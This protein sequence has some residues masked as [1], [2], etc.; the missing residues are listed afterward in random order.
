MTERRIWMRGLALAA[1]TGALV[2]L[3][4]CSGPVRET[5]SPA[6]SHAAPEPSAAPEPAPAV[7]RALGREFDGTE[8]QLDLSDVSPEDMDEILSL[9][10]RLPRLSHIKT[11]APDGEDR[12]QLEE[13]SRLRE[14]LDREIP[15]SCRFELFGH[16]VSSEDE[17]ISYVR[18]YIGDEQLPSLRKALPLLSGCRR[19]VLDDCMLTYEKLAELREEFPERGLVWRV[20]YGVESSL[21]DDTTI[22]SGSLTDE[23]CDVLK[24]CTEVLYLDVGENHQQT[25]FRFLDSMTKL[26]VVIVAHTKFNY[27]DFVTHCPDL[28]YLEL[29]HTPV[30]DLTPLAGCENLRHLSVESILTLTDITPLYQLKGLERLRICIVPKVPA[31]QIRALS[32]ELPDTLLITSVNPYWRR[33]RNGNRVERYI[34]LQEQIGYSYYF[35]ATDRVDWDYIHSMGYDH[36]SVFTCS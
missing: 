15:I 26:Q 4:G 2:L 35:R 12:W 31:E 13:L 34:L 5:S 32:E 8:T 28:E 17:E 36:R 33:D 23:N 9:I 1:L 29:D 22:W 14:G 27:C 11:E 20:R 3:A 18:E 25:N 7:I 6:P 24:Y 19:L 16:T 21:T 10:P 30:D